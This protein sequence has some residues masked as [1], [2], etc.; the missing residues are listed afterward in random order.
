MNKIQWHSSHMYFQNTSDGYFIFRQASGA[1][2]FQL[3][4]SGGI[5]LSTGSWRAPLFYDS[6][7]TAYYTD[8]ASTSVLNQLELTGANHH[9][10]YINPGNGYE[11]M[12]RYNGGTGS[13]WYVGKRTASDLVGTGNFHFYSEA[14][15]R[16]VAGI[17]T[18]G[19]FI[20]Y[21]NVTAYSDERL[22]TNWQPMPENYVTR[23]AQ[24]KVGIYDRTNENGITQVGVS[25]Q[26][27]Q[28][29]LP[30]AILTAQDEMQ[31]L[32][33]AYGNAALASAV[34]LAK[35]VVDLRNRV[36]H[37]E[38]LIHNLIGD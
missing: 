36:A 30:Q 31:T 33:V 18:S 32:S 24:V 15:V 34:E 22:K 5:G 20:A 14:A 17:D 12:V 19:N 2:P 16:T 13:S 26:S 38:S 1:E 23:L 29:L 3:Q 8:P 10:L 11:A 27:L 28:E 4:V 9:Y 6:N 37:L 25:A 35:E 21:G 7:D